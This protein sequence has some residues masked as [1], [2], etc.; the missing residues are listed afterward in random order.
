MQ[1]GV[2]SDLDV[3]YVGSLPVDVAP[4]EQDVRPLRSEGLSM[5]G[6]AQ[7]LLAGFG[8]GQASLRA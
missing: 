2:P 3:T 1:E 5:P 4:E 6:W 8:S 7:R